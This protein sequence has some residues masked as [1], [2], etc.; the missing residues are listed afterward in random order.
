M[1]SQP[2]EQA[3]EIRI[4]PNILHSRDNQTMNTGQLKEYSKKSNFLQKSRRR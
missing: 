3:V 4:L 1:T 2:G